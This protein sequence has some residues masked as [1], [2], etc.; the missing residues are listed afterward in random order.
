MDLGAAA[1]GLGADEVQ[2]VLG[3]EGQDDPGHV[4]QADIGDPRPQA[5]CRRPKNSCV[6]FLVKPIRH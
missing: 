5:F 2:L 6:D 1:G 3:P 4:V